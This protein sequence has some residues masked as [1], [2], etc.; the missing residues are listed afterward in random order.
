MAKL[1]DLDF[2]TD[3]VVKVS[4]RKSNRT[5]EQNSRLWALYK[6]IA[7][8]IGEDDDSIHEYMKNKFLKIV[9]IVN[10]EEVLTFQSTAKLNTKQMEVYQTQIEAWAATELGWSW[11]D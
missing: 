7:D 1:N 8:H 4:E 11:D 9:K 5:L 2:E 3:W 10:G 6:S